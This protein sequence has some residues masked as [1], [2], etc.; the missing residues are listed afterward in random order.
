MA[1]DTTVDP[2]DTR[3]AALQANVRALTETVRRQDRTIVV[4]A[5]AITANN[6]RS[7]AHRFADLVLEADVL[8]R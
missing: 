2:R 8:D 4:Y 1:E 5:T 3:I 6:Q 7:L